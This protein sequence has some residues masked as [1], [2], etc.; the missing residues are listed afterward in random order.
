MKK[1]QIIHI[2]ENLE[3]ELEQSILLTCLTLLLMS[4]KKEIGLSQL[5]AGTVF[6]AC[7]DEVRSKLLMGFP[8]SALQTLKDH[9]LVDEE[10][11]IPVDLA[12]K[13][14]EV[15]PSRTLTDLIKKLNL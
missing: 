10:A 4:P 5:F 13:L 15:A 9:K 12:K 3:R 11:E 8:E 2:L 7:G 6:P 1:L 14:G